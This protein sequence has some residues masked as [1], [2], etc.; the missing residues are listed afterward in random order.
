M[1]A[2]SSKR[3]AAH[4]RRCMNPHCPSMGKALVAYRG[5]C[6]ACYK[7]LQRKLKAEG[8]VWIDAEAAGVC[9]PKAKPGC[10]RFPHF[11]RKQPV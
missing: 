3:H 6:Q 5:L 9:L 11:G 2:T 7:S 10:K 1:K 8:L 4:S